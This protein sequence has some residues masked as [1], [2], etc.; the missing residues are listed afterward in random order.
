MRAMLAFGTSR[1]ILKTMNKTNIK[2]RAGF[3]GKLKIETFRDGVKI[4]ETDW[5]ENRIVASDTHG[6]NIVMRQLAGDNTYPI[7]IDSAEIGT[8]ILTPADGTTDLV[9]PVLTGVDIGN[10]VVTDVDE[11]TLSIFMS[12][13]AL[14][15]GTYKEFLLRCGT[16]CFSAIVIS[17]NY[18]KSAG[19]DSVFTYV[20]TLGV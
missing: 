18:S 6:R 11:L 16:K 4:R 9:T 14:A 15:D 13:L 17:P 2:E 19:E 12:D 1:L 8:G 10:A 20:I 5:M 3:R 7:V